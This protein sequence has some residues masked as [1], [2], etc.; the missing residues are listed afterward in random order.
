MAVDHG[1][2]RWRGCGRLGLWFIQQNASFADIAEAQLGVLAQAALDESAHAR[3]RIL[4]ERVEIGL[5]ADD[6]GER[7]GDR[8]AAAEEHG[9]GEHLVED[10]AEGPDIGAAIDGLAARL[11]RRHVG[12]GAENH[13]RLGHGQR[14]G[15][16]LSGT[17]IRACVS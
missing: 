4:R 12:R 17:G 14:E 10:D 13:A 6:R 5:A 8:L 11:L 1:R 7:I 3:R 16:G 15:G 2:R 9:A